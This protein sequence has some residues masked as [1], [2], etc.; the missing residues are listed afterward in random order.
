MSD[1]VVSCSL[2]HLQFIFDDGTKIYMANMN[3]LELP[4]VFGFS[5][6]KRASKEFQS[7]D[8][9]SYFFELI[10]FS[11]RNV[12]ISQVRSL[13]VNIHYRNWFVCLQHRSN[14]MCELKLKQK[15]KQCCNSQKNITW[16]SVGESRRNGQCVLHSVPGEDASHPWIHSFNSGKLLYSVRCLITSNL[17]LYINENLLFVHGHFHSFTT[18]SLEPTT[19]IRC[20]SVTI[21]RTSTPCVCVRLCVC[22]EV[23]VPWVSKMV[24]R[25]LFTVINSIGVIYS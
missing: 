1:L 23:A 5:M 19:P 4:S 13:R 17:Y 15:R 14:W 8:F 24:T 25:L 6:I 21:Y 22:G 3:P 9:I 12:Q 7:H 2:S 10:H 18:D 16:L 20:S 11:Q